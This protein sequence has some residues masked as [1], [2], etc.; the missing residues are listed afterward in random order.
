MKIY[1]KAINHLRNNGYKMILKENYQTQENTHRLYMEIEVNGIRYTDSWLNESKVDLTFLKNFTNYEEAN[2]YFYK[3][4]K[5]F[6]KGDKNR[7]NSNNAKR[8]N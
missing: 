7:R 5:W 4:K 3:F 2:K 1:K 8:A 6:D